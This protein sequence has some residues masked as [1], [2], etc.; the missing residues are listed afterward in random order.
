ML[1]PSLPRISV[2]ERFS[3][4]SLPLCTERTPFRS[5]IVPTPEQ[6][7]L[8][9][10]QCHDECK[11]DPR[12]RRRVPK[13]EKAKRIFVNVLDDGTGRVIRSAVRH[14]KDL[15]KDAKRADDR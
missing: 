15:R 4:R 3:E 8:D 14:H 5:L 1:E 11:Q 10:R 9:Q 12:N 7:E 6:S 13:P 2:V